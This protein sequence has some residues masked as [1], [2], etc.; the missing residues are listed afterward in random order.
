[1]SSSSTFERKIVV[2]MCCGGFFRNE[3]RKLRVL[4]GCLYIY[5][6]ICSGVD[7]LEW[8]RNESKNESLG[9][10]GFSCAVQCFLCALL[11]N[12]QRQFW[13]MSLTVTIFYM[14][15]FFYLTFFTCFICF[16]KWYNFIYI[17]PKNVKCENL[18]EWKRIIVV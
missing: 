2:Y 4:W 5:T 6:F 9:F 18:M 11:S 10:I 15:F 1:M 17:S 12:F 7:G 8:G 3:G 14:F 13:E 16:C